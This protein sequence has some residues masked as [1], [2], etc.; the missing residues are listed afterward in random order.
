MIEIS[1]NGAESSIVR[2]FSHLDLGG[3]G[4]GVRCPALFSS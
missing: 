4:D 3:R 1:F 2:L